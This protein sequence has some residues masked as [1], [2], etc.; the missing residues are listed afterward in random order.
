VVVVAVV[1]GLAMSAVL[2]AAP[3]DKMAQRPMMVGQP[4]LVWVVR[5]QRLVPTLR[6][7]RLVVV[8]DRPHYWVERQE[9]IVM[10]EQVVVVIGVDQPV[11]IMSQIQWLV[12]VVVQVFITRHTS[13]PLSYIQVMGLHQATRITHLGVL[14]GT[15]VVLLHRV[16]PEQ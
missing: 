10:V 14:L 8:V 15:P 7:I 3:L 12:V 2:A 1:L 16:V 13:L 6:L 9:R 11:V 5:K 4:M